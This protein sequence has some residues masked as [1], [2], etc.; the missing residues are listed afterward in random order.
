MDKLKEIKKRRN[1]RFRMLDY[2]DSDID[3]LIS[4]VEQFK[5]EKEWLMEQ[6]IMHMYHYRLQKK[7]R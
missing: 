5:K 4:E 1:S 7:L 3:W 6:Y 2:V